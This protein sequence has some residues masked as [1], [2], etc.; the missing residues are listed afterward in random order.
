MQ[1]Q[2]I[3]TSGVKA[4]RIGLGV[5]RMAKLS[6]SEANAAVATALAQGINFL[7]PQTSTLRVKAHVNSP[8][9]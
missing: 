6:Q 4:A 8:K 2:E 1:L 3:G 9:L 5:M 7:I